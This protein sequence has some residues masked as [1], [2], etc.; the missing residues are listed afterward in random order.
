MAKNARDWPVSKSRI[1]C[2]LFIGLFCSTFVR[3]Q[4]TI[5]SLNESAY[6]A[7]LDRL[8]LRTAMSES[9]LM[10]V[11]RYEPSFAAESQITIVREN[12]KWRLFREYSERGNI[13][14]RLGRIMEETGREDVDWLITQ[15]PVKRQEIVLPQRV[16]EELQQQFINSLNRQLSLEIVPR[17]STKGQIGLVLDQTRYRIWYR[18]AMNVEFAIWGS[19][20]DKRTRSL[21]TAIVRWAKRLSRVSTSASRSSAELRAVMRL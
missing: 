7:V 6:N 2:I 20:I 13:Y 19:D 9:E 16:I 5:P 11:V 1:A 18:G 8:F 3:G 17:E 10:L 15:V 14:V 4:T 12:G 21:E